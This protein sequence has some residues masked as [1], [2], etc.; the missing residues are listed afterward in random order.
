MHEMALSASL[1]RVIEDSAA[2]EGFRAVRTVWLEIGA[3][4][5]VEPEALRFGFEVLSRGTVADGAT[6]RI[7]DVGASAWCEACARTVTV[8]A[9]FDAC[10]LCGTDALRPTGGREI[11]VRE[12]EVT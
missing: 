12:L 4:A 2:R 6:L 11:R 5:A 1:L 8:S 10:P 9:R 7:V 3:L